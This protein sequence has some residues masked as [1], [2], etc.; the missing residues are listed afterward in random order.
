MKKVWVVGDALNLCFPMAAGTDRV[1]NLMQ[2]HLKVNPTEQSQ[3]F[4]LIVIAVKGR[5]DLC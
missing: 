2:V 3:W 4:L 5:N 1:C